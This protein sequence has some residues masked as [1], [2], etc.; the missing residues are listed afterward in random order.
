MKLVGKGGL[1]PPNT[2][3]SCKKKDCCLGICQYHA[4]NAAVPIR[5][6]PHMYLAEAAG[7]EPTT[8]ESKSVVFANYTTP[9][10]VP[11][12]GL[13]AINV[14][15]KPIG[16]QARLNGFQRESLCITTSFGVATR[17]ERRIDFCRTLP[18]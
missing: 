7:L 6:F 2:C 8:T 4:Y 11:A 16:E 9:Q 5:L 18:C 13:V 15:A 1:E 12:G 17:T 14:L 10:C 3:S